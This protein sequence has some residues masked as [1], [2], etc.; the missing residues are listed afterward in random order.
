VDQSQEVF[1]ITDE[2]NAAYIK[3]NQIMEDTIG[4]VKALENSMNH[5]V[6]YLEDLKKFTQEM[7]KVL[8]VIM[9]IANKTNTLSLNASIEAVRAG[10]SGKGFKIVA[11]EIQKFSQATTE[12]SRQVSSNLKELNKEMEK[13]FHMVE[14]SKNNLHNVVDKTS[15]LKNYFKQLS[16]HI[17]RSL[18]STRDISNI[19]T[20]ELSEMQN[21]EQ[22]IGTIHQTISDFKNQ[23]GF[24]SGAADKISHAAEDIA[25]MINNFQM[26]NFQTFARRQMSQAIDKIK[27]IFNKQINEG[28]VSESQ[29]FD[30]DYQQIPGT[31]PPQYHTAYDQVVDAQIQEVI[32]S[33]KNTLAAEAPLYDKTFLACAITDKKGY[34]PTHL[35]ALS[36]P[37]TGDYE[38]DLAKCRNKRIFNDP[39]SLKAAQNKTEFL[40]QVYM[41]DDG[42]QNIDLSMPIRIFDRHWGC[43]R[44]GYTFIH[45][46]V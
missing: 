13:S 7:G 41:R 12:A 31:N 6:Q 43:L 26:N 11:R 35:K 18:D 4:S 5:T 3:G 28:R 17:T 8:R 14:D 45:R 30:T 46:E 2:A 15:T 34:A 20:N 33:L 23:F 32:E 44:A 39:V 37:P 25:R 27:D 42:T 40:L 38:H 10:E 29:I 22:K 9:D 36:E 1:S 21:I 24:L 16:S 19:A